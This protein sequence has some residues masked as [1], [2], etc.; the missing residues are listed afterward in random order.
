MAKF[1]FRFHRDAWTDITVTARNAEEA[2]QKAQDKYNTGD[3]S[4]ED[5][6]FENTYCEQVFPIEKGI[7]PNIENR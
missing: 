4:D 5:E 2:E 7:Y 1:T 3:Y 6:D